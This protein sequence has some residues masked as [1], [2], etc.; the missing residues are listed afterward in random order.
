MAGMS[1]EAAIQ[2]VVE[3]LDVER[4]E[5]RQALE[6]AQSEKYNDPYRSELQ[7]DHP[8]CNCGTTIPRDKVT[9]ICHL[10]LSVGGFY[11]SQF[12]TWCDKCWADNYGP[13]LPLD[14]VRDMTIG[15]HKD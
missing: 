4:S 7:S 2:E 14:K 3:T 1:V 13:W 11:S 15:I 12:I 6:K 9:V 8:C 5:A 10:P